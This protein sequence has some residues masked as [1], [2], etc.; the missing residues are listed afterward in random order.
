MGLPL[1]AKLDGRTGQTV[2][3]FFTF[4]RQQ[5]HGPLPFRGT[6]RKSALSR[7]ASP[8]AQRVSRPVACPPNVNTIGGA[9]PPNPEGPLMAVKPAV[10]VTR[11][12]PDAGLKRIT[13]A[14]AAEVWT[15]PLP[16]PY[17]VLRQK[18]AD[19]EGLVA[20]LTDK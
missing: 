16:P 3:S 17:A 13:Q 19:C 2:R 5:L 10:F 9:E 4:P 18:V 12:I 11:I 20:L 1:P 15:D 6:N 8:R 7:G 14:C